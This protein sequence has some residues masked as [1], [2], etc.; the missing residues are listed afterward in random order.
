MHEVGDSAEVESK[1]SGLSRSWAMRNRYLLSLILLLTACSGERV[2]EPANISTEVFDILLLGGSI[3][4]GEIV[5]SIIGDIGIRGD[6]ISAIGD[7]GENEADLVLDVSGLAVAPGFIDIH[8]HAVRT[9]L[10]D[11]IFRWPDAE[12]VIRQGVTTVS[13]THLTLPTICSV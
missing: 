10:D 3:Y 4:S 11:G 2:E 1:I 7:L 9:G 13:Y 6:R 8:T 5:S 12:N